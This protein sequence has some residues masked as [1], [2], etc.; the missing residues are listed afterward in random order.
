MNCNH[1][2]VMLSPAWGIR[3]KYGRESVPQEVS[4]LEDYC[5]SCGQENAVYL[6]PPKAV[7]PEWE[8]NHD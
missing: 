4:D 7:I 2:S 8:D 3:L 5:E 1:D 6:R